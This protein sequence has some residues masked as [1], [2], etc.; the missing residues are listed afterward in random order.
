MNAVVA[1]YFLLF[2]MI[3]LFHKSEMVLMMCRL[4][5]C[6]TGKRRRRL[7]GSLDWAA[8]LSPSHSS[9]TTTEREEEDS[10]FLF[11]EK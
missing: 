3:Y 4:T 7:S 2:L 5:R 1:D 11:E 8:G 6:W 10:F 9:D